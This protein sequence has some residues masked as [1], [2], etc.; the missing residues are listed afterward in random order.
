MAR[1]VV[2]ILGAIVIAGCGW[3]AWWYIGAEGQRS[4]F[5][6]WLEKQR[7]RGWQAEAATVDMAG[8]PSA[9]QLTVT[10]LN[11]A[12][13]RNG[14]SWQ[15]PVA[16]A[17]SRSSAP[18]RI[19]VTWP[20]TQ[21]LGTTEDQFT[22]QAASLS[23]LLD[24][25]PGPSM[26]LREAATDA[27]GA[28]LTARS[29]WKGSASRIGISVKER[30]EDISPPNSYDLRAEASKIKLPPELLKDLD[31]TG[32]LK[33]TVDRFTLTGH[34]AFDQP[35]DRLTLEESRMAMRAATLREVGFA[36]GDMKL[37]IKGSVQVEDSGY[38][39]GKL[40]V[41]ARE[42]RQIVQLAVKTGVIGEGTADTIA[43]AVQLL[44]ALTG[45]GDDLSLPLTLKS[46]EVRLGPF[47][48]ADAPRL[49][50]PR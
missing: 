14:W 33:P 38:P 47:T 26:E 31:P 11:L 36:W 5:E 10:G 17:E 37:V 30:G 42:W 28:V 23:T 1:I 3:I 8:F 39:R 21:S 29:G 45:A 44:T 12:D 9:F 20:E 15:V 6:L 24:L 2:L 40:Q 50:P 13:P 34:A 43:G 32:L 18:T 35:I 25:R 48:I 27:S 4:A 22:L 7:E 46:G 16:K 19:A 41:D 49:A